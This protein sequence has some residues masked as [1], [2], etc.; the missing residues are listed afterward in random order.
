[1]SMVVEASIMKIHVNRIPFEGLREETTYDPA[2]L[3]LKRRDL[4]LQEPIALSAFITKAEDELVVQA[5]IACRLHL[6]CARC[7][8]AFDSPLRT[9]AMLTYHVRPTDVV[10][11]TEDL[12]QEIILAY[13]MIPLCRRTCKGLCPACGQNLNLQA[14]PHQKESRDGPPETETQSSPAR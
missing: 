9:S 4:Q 7:L 13:P 3:D 12:R 11:I 6:S 10:D 5:D 1:M 14:C 8:G 2:L